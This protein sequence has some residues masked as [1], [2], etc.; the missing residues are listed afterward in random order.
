MFDRTK[1]MLISQVIM[2]GS[3][4]AMAILTAA[5]LMTPGWLLGLGLILGTGVALNLPTW[6]ALL[7]DLVPRPMIP[8]A[9]ALNSAGFNVARAVGPAIGGLIVATLGP[10]AGFGI[11]ALT[12]AAVIV[13]L[14]IIGSS[15]NSPV[16]GEHLV[17]HRDQPRSPLRPLHT[18]VPPPA[19]A[20]GPVR[21]HLGGRPVG[22]A[23]AHR[24]TGRRGRGPRLLAGG[25]GCRSP[26]GSLHPAQRIV[27]RLA[28]TGRRW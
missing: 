15:I 6:N 4:L 26:G 11:N 17:R 12:Y 20:G 27:G 19:V 14:I 25:D 13:A 8:N 5:D 10:Q 3:A 22:P 1:L 2:G 7:P 9:V 18:G 24:V 23:G 16:A 21:H 28:S